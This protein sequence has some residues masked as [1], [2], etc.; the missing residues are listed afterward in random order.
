MVEEEKEI[1][2]I[3]IVYTRDSLD[4]CS[5]EEAEFLAKAAIASFDKD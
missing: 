2:K 4:E 3:K 1:S 5:E